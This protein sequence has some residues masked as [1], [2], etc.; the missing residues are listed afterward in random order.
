M[1]PTPPPSWLPI[2]MYYVLRPQYWGTILSTTYYLLPRY[3]VV[4]TTD[5][6]YGMH[7]VAQQQP[8]TRPQWLGPC[9]RRPVRRDRSAV[10]GP[11]GPAYCGMSHPRG[12]RSFP[13]LH[14]SR[15]FVL[16]VTDTR[17]T[18][19]TRIALRRAER[20]VLMLPR[21]LHCMPT[22]VPVSSAYHA[23]HGACGASCLAVCPH[24]TSHI[25][26]HTP[27]WPPGPPRGPPMS[28]P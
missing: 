18:R 7:E 3:V 22:A 4:R 6:C 20:A 21:V 2:Q 13:F 8:V 28:C 1:L 23:F 26:D 15:S 27:S 19:A 24:H 11:A 5:T 25:T 14:T 10:V 9:P 17:N 12:V 16:F